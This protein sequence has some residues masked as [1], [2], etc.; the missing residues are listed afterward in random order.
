[1]G[2]WW[3]WTTPRPRPRPRP[4]P[5]F[6]LDGLA[7]E[8]DYGGLELG[9]ELLEHLA[10]AMVRSSASRTFCARRRP[11]LVFVAVLGVHRA[12]RRSGELG[13][14]LHEPTP[15]REKT[16]RAR[17]DAVELFAERRGFLVADLLG[18]A[19]ARTRAVRIVASE[20]TRARAAMRAHDASNQIRTRA[21]DGNTRR[22]EDARRHRPLRA[23]EKCH[24]WRRYHEEAEPMPGAE[25]SAWSAPRL[26]TKAARR[27][28]VGLDDRLRRSSRVSKL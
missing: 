11:G 26:R 16:P 23:P 7:L 22:G 3:G 15:A 8:D 4:H 2:G 24:S 6:V 21:R 25:Q 9:G 20:D 18:T 28:T 14:A 1:M 12:L 5:F 10:R 27:G 17:T 13:D 19:R